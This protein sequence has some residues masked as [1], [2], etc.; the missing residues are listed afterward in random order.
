MCAGEAQAGSIA[1]R[2]RN[3][4]YATNGESGALNSRT[5]RMGS[6]FS[7][8]DM[9]G[10][11][12]LERSPGSNRRGWV[13]SELKRTT[14]CF[15]FSRP[16]SNVSLKAS[17]IIRM[18]GGVRVKL[19][20]SCGTKERERERSEIPELAK[21]GGFHLDAHALV[22]PQMI[23]HGSAGRSRLYPDIIACQ[24]TG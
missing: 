9:G 18:R 14:T 15:G 7:Y 8:Q 4:S 1:W 11:I 13:Q 20:I 10:G 6:T 5:A 22:F 3:W 24:A 19:L 23:G 21:R 16:S 2:L 12:A 17:T